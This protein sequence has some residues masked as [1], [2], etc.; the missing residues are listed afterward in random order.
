[1]L[2]ISFFVIIYVYVNK[3]CLWIFFSFWQFSLMLYIWG[4]LTQRRV[5]I[6]SIDTCLFV[7][8]SP[9]MTCPGSV[10]PLMGGPCS[11]GWPPSTPPLNGPHSTKEGGDTNR[12]KRQRTIEPKLQESGNI[13]LGLTNL[14]LV[15]SSWGCIFY[16]Q[17]LWRCNRGTTCCCVC[18]YFWHGSWSGWRWRRR[19]R[20]RR[21]Q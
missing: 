14:A 3:I 16:F 17:K 10:T 11:T 20:R 1:M 9:M 15:I 5:E 2:F 13:L 12:R 19:R 8:Y 18:C 7:L 6:G 21:R 4:A